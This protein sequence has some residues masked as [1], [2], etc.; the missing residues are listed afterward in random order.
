MTQGLVDLSAWLRANG[1]LVFGAC[2]AAAAALLV[3]RAVPAGRL[4]LDTAALRLPVFG[5]IGRLAGT[6]VFARAMGMLVA[7]GVTLLE[8]LDVSR[9]LL[10]NRR[11][12]ARVGAAGETV[13]HGGALAPAL[14]ARG[15]F[16]QMLPQM[17]AVGETT[18]SL[19]DAFGEV[20][21]FHEMLLS[22]AVKRLGVVLEPAMIVFTG[23]VV[24]YVYVAFFLALFSMAGM[25]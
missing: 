20:A 21:R 23:L 7:S 12:A 5:R 14:R 9:G 24:G 25:S 22:I 6:A 19:A 18:G 11:L 10:R 15:E 4:A 1:L 3:V 2:A 8:S 16:M 17:V 13:L